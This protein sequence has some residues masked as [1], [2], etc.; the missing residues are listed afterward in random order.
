VKNNGV[1]I[2]TI[3]IFLLI[4]FVSIACQQQPYEE[5]LKTVIWN[6]IVFRQSRSVTDNQ[7]EMT[8]NKFK[9]V[10]SSDSFTD[11]ERAKFK[12]HTNSVFIDFIGSGGGWFAD[13][14]D[15]NFK[16]MVSVPCDS[17]LSGIDKIIRR[18][19]DDIDKYFI[20]GEWRF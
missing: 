19:L 7:F 17:I 20:D 4:I 15:S 8:V 18:I 11:E 3:L 2:S 16:L 10:F 12:N 14:Y 9:V 5:N 6:G 1:R 13:S